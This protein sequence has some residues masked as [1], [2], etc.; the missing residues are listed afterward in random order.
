MDKQ[1]AVRTLTKELGDKLGR[2]AVIEEVYKEQLVRN[3]NYVY[4]LNNPVLVDFAHGCY[5]YDDIS[6]NGRDMKNLLD[7]LLRKN[8]SF[9]EANYIFLGNTPGGE[10]TFT[11]T[12]FT[13][14]AYA[15]IGPD[16]MNN[17]EKNF[18]KNVS[19]DMFSA[20]DMLGIKNFAKVYR[21]Y[22][23]SEK[24]DLESK[25]IREFV[26]RVSAL[27]YDSDGEI[28]KAH[29]DPFGGL[30]GLN[31]YFKKM[32]LTASLS[33]TEDRK[34]SAK[35][36]PTL[37]HKKNILRVIEEIQTKKGLG[38][39]FFDE[40]LSRLDKDFLK[41]FF[42]FVFFLPYED[43]NLKVNKDILR[44]YDNKLDYIS[45]LV[46]EYVK[47]EYFQDYFDILNS[48]KQKQVVLTLSTISE[49]NPAYDSFLWIKGFRNMGLD[50]MKAYKNDTKSFIEYFNS[51]DNYMRKIILNDIMGCDATNED[52]IKWLNENHP[53][54]IREVGFNG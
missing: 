12:R 5:Y 52:V 17:L 2:Q 26:G 10:K 48:D 41:D 3:A 33:T 45:I 34:S 9:T 15:L 31:E 47:G 30:D 14:T 23:D 36:Y 38:D 54:L 4:Q 16:E 53:E 42:N 21:I 49:R 18:Y 35:N 29:F 27:E 6:I 24:F 19:S 32:G 25:L 37:V 8:N 11:D 7:L 50:Y 28:N 39:S 40:Y 13:A 44:L 22:T 43:Q 46:K 51:K 20:M 1:T